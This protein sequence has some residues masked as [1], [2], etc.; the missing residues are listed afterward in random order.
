MLGS[1]RTRE[2]EEGKIQ[3][4][5][6]RGRGSCLGR[7]FPDY[8]TPGYPGAFALK[9]SSVR[10]FHSRLAFPLSLFNLRHKHIYSSKQNLFMSQEPDTGRP[11]CSTVPGRSGCT[12]AIWHQT[13]TSPNPT[14][15]SE[16]NRPL[17]LWTN[18]HYF[19]VTLIVEELINGNNCNQTLHISFPALPSSENWV[20]AVAAAGPTRRRAGLQRLCPRPLV[21]W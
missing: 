3:K 11:V 13:R 8:T 15:S 1:L 18:L 9:N 16:E 14:I 19:E 2:R 4:Y 12:S 5:P 6:I 10:D 20:N 21:G 17:S 7:L